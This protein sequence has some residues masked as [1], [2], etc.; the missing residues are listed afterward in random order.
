MDN[1]VE[2]QFIRLIQTHLDN[3]WFVYV[4]EA[5]SF[6]FNFPFFPIVLCVCL[7][8]KYMTLPQLLVICIGQIFLIAIKYIIKRKRPFHYRGIKRL[9]RMPFD[10]YSFP[11]NHAYNAFILSFLLNSTLYYIPYIV[12]FSR[13]YLGVHYPTDTIGGALLALCCSYFL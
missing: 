11:S 1:V 6:L 5:F 3:D 4:M 9:D 13:V 7:Y 10:N 12:S 8:L 2:L